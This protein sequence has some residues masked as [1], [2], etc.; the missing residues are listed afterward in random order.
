MA[1]EEADEWRFQLRREFCLLSTCKDV[2]KTLSGIA[3]EYKVENSTLS[4]ERRKQKKNV[5]H[6]IYQ[7]HSAAAWM[8]KEKGP[9]SCPW[10]Y[11][12]E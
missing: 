5:L 3:K 2:V 11:H 9:R 8:L 7:E 1:L 4:W 10:I 6:M 12:Q